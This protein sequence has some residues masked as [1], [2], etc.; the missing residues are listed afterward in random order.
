MA[1]VIMAAPA[2]AGTRQHPF[3][4][5]QHGWVRPLQPIAQAGR[6]AAVELT[7]MMTDKLPGVILNGTTTRYAW[8]KPKLLKTKPSGGFSCIAAIAL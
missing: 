6:A 5:D 8:I 1:M 2:E 3:P 7:K 4:F